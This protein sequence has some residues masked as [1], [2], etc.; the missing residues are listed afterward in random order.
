MLH[1]LSLGKEWHFINRSKQVK[2]ELKQALKEDFTE[3][4][5]L[6]F[7]KQSKITH[8]VLENCDKPSDFLK[9]ISKEIYNNGEFSV[10]EIFTQ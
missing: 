1:Y 9:K 5:A 8:I 4:D 10:L 6:K 3:N 7:L 2:F